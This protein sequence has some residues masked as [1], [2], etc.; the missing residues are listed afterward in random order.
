MYFESTIFFLGLF[1]IFLIFAIIFS[2]IRSFTLKGEI[3]R[4]KEE[5]YSIKK[6]LKNNTLQEIKE[7][8]QEVKISV[9]A[10]DETL[11]AKAAISKKLETTPLKVIKIKEE[12]A[13]QPQQKTIKDDL[14]VKFFK[15]ISGGNLVAKV[16]I[17]ILFFGLSFLLKY[18]IDNGLLS[19]EVRILGSAVLGFVLI[20]LGLKLK[21]SKEVY[22][23]ILQ[24]GG[25]GILYLATFAAI[26]LYSMIPTPLAFFI[27]VALCFISVVFALSQK[28]LSLAVL[29]FC[30]AYLTPV[31][32]SDGGGNHKVLFAFYV[33]VSIAILVIS[34]FRSWRVLNL[35]G[36]IFT[37]VVFGLWMMRSYN[38]AFYLETQIFIIANLLIYGVLAV[39]LFLRNE[40]SENFNLFIDLLLLFGTPL[41]GYSAQYYITEIWKFGPA[42]SALCFGIFY[43]FGTFIVYKINKTSAVKIL[44]FGLGLALTFATIAIPLALSHQLSSIVWMIEGTALSVAALYMR[45]YKVAY[46]GLFV[47][48][49]GFCIVFED[50]TLNFLLYHDFDFILNFSI[51]SAVSLFNACIFYHFKDLHVSLKTTSYVI[52]GISA[53][54]W[55]FWLFGSAKRVYIF[56]YNPTLLLF[57]IAVWIWYIIGKKQNFIILKYA[58]ISL[59]PVLGLWLFLDFTYKNISGEFLSIMTLFLLASFI[60]AY[61]YLYLEQNTKDA[62]LKLKP[63]LHVTLLWF[64]LGFIYNKT[65]LFLDSTLPWGYFIVKH[66]LLL[67]LFS[68]VILL[69]Y[70]LQ[71]KEIFPFSNFKKE[72]WFFGLLPVLI[73]ILIR[74]LMGATYSGFVFDLKFIPILNPLE[75]SA[76]FAL[77]VIVFFCFISKKIPQEYLHVN[78]LEKIS[79]IL[80]AV[81]GFI[82]VN[83]ILLRILA[84]GLDVPWYF[85][86][87]WTNSIIQASFS[88]FWTFLALGLIVWSNKNGKRLVWLI[89][90]ILLGIVVVK[91]VFM[92]SVRLEGLI[93]AFAF[94]GVA[95]LMLVIGYLA[96][97]PPKKEEIKKE[98]KQ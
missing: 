11:S 69:V 20:G 51:M 27:L 55:I 91:L 98:M 44:Y 83:S 75:E 56:D 65:S 37:F 40:K 47:T 92:D 73:Y 35:L 1:L 93:R 66:S 29:A 74:L 95:L 62:I 72:Y 19:P 57:S 7:P 78:T 97:L 87:L 49:L 96:P 90:G 17:V 89:G 88:V 2:F 85:Y 59:W 9:Q 48:F 77:M 43:I 36:F 67:T 15:W 81:L 38:H 23:L 68:A 8:K 41:I 82:W 42:F 76:L 13:K 4:L 84:F 50:R 60:S 52:L 21:K 24:G 22:A 14:F 70:F 86:S 32:L 71:K 10:K 39:V 80:P 64:V 53:V 6:I 45:Q 26:K 79:Y 28:A 12:S 5:I 31:L 63:L 25:V 16:A 34:K 18:S 61:F 94:I 33:L 54:T 58:V 46:A 30:G 3:S